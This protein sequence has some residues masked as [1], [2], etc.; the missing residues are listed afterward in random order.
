MKKIEI[1]LDEIKRGLK[2]KMLFEC[3]LLITVGCI[4]YANAQT[5][6]SP[7]KPGIIMVSIFFLTCI[8][9]LPNVKKMIWQM[10]GQGI[11]IFSIP[12]VMYSC[13]ERM[14]HN[15]IIEILP[16]KNAVNYWIYLLIYLMILVI[17]GN[18]SV[19]SL[20]FGVV[21]MIA[22]MASDFVWT[23]RGSP[24]LP[25]DIFSIGTAKNIISEYRF[26]LSNEVAITMLICILFVLVSSK[27]SALKKLK[28]AWHYRMVILEIFFFTLLIPY[29]VNVK[30]QIVSKDTMI[31]DRWNQDKT[32]KENGVV[33]AFLE[34]MYYSSNQKPEGYNT[35]EI[36]RFLASVEVEQT[37]VNPG[38]T[39]AVNVIAIMNESFADLRVVGDFQTNQEYLSFYNSLEEN[40]V[41]GNLLV[42]IY[43]ANTPN[44][45][46]EFLTG[47]SMAFLPKG[48]IPFQSVVDKDA[49]SLSK[50]LKKDD[51]YTDAFHM[52]F[53]SSWNRTTAYPNLGFDEMHFLDEY[54][55]ENLSFVRCYPSD[56][57][58]YKK[59]IEL[60]EQ[61]SHPKNF[62]FNVTMQNHGGYDLGST[63]EVQIVDG[64]EFPLTNEYLSV[65][66][67]SDE[68]LKILV[69]YFTNVTEPTVL[70][71]F[72]DHQPA[73]DKTFLEKLSGKTQDE[74]TL[75]ELQKQY[76][77]PFLIWTN[78]DIEERTIDKISANYLST[79]L[80]ETAGLE[81]PAYNKF[82]N[83]LY[84][85]YPVINANGVIDS[86]GNHLS[87]E[88][89][90][91]DEMIDL[92][93]NIQ[94]YNI[95]DGENL[96]RKFY[97]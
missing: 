94:Y 5:T 4:W 82:L 8:L 53:S 42:S 62:I 92:Y 90:E 34:N 7:L 22:G 49:V 14:N 23:F 87:I 6:E 93:K 45:E 20:I 3:I 16:W 46:Y 44:S 80:L 63:G 15:Q 74:L 73:I 85:K 56:E 69:D 72:G 86:E 65:L 1:L 29:C 35:E 10:T 79:L 13:V 32:Y 51:F 12:L 67:S 18:I 61:S 97:E 27:V 24:L 38:E 95:N 25:W 84:L 47:N 81:L 43:G 71:M 77:V 50:I 39:E 59:V 91:E 28:T 55:D 41:K 57:A 78:Y 68:A 31:V 52:Y 21:C 2:F 26:Y 60:Y 66:K 96:Q 19:S 88:E 70:L 17:I 9:W 36:E 30:M 11:I 48:S 58:S 89:A 64:E 40:T 75:E 54:I 76:T 83:N 37:I 33:L